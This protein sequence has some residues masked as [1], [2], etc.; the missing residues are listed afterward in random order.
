MNGQARHLGRAGELLAGFAVD[1]QAPP[2]CVL[3]I[4]VGAVY[5]QCARA[6]QR[7]R[8]C[9]AGA[10][11]TRSA[12]AG[13]DGQGAMLAALTAGELG[14]ATFDRDLPQRQKNTLY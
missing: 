8:S 11:R 6:I 1:G 14:G 5:F 12:A 13:A 2:Q 9:G 10:G 7:S 4:S 3:V